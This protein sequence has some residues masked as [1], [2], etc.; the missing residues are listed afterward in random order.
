MEGGHWRD[1]T[2][3]RIGSGR[4]PIFLRKAH[5]LTDK[6]SIVLADFTNTTG[7]TVFDGTLRQG[8]S[9][10]LE[11]SPFLSII[12][13]QQIQ[14]T[15]GLMGKPADAKLTPAIARELCQRT[16]SAAV[17]IGSIAQI[18]AQ[19]LLIVKAV[20]CV[21]GESL[22]SAEA[23]AS[24]KTHVLD[25]LG[26]VASELRRKLGESVNTVRKFDTPLELATTPSLEALQSFSL[27]WKT[28]VG[29][30]DSA[31]AVPLFQRA[32]TLDP[33]FAMAY[34]A[35]GV[36]Y[37]N[38]GERSLA[39]ENLRQAFELR[40]HVSV[41]EKMFIEASYYDMVTGDLEKE[42]RSS[43]VWAQTYPRD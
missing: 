7:D 30:G 12:S 43:E 15:L 4:L 21:S 8:L 2:G 34:A 35:L 16:G 39:S 17:L 13:D 29:K 36:A 5:A 6:D 27:G 31:S 23:Q 32:I 42:Q 9:V 28:L 38:L 19:Y 40:E 14:Q 33:N 41:R 22:A 20:N 26:T 24:D 10:Q 18:G 25:A 3:H 37:S 1:D 11:Q